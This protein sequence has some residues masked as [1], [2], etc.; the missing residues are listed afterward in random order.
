MEVLKKDENEG[1]KIYEDLA[2][3]TLQREPTN[4]EYKTA[5]LISSKRG[6]HLI[7]NFIAT[8][9]KFANI[10]RRLEAIETKGSVSVSQVNPVGPKAY[11]SSF[12]DDQ[13]M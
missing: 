8:E 9:A 10:M 11:H 12:D 7:E 2:E 4:E 3:N 1:W 5:N 6:L 13:L